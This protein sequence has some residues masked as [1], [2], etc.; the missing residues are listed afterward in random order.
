MERAIHI[1]TSG[2]SYAGWKE[3]FYPKGMKPA[4]RLAHF[5]QRE[6]ETG[7]LAGVF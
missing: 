4:E 5:A 7:E 1:G 6:A 3:T 2:F